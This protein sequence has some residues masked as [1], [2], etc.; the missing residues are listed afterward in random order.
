MKVS[1]IRTCFWQGV[2]I[3]PNVARADVDSSIKTD[4]TLEKVYNLYYFFHLYPNINNYNYEPL[5]IILHVYLWYQGV[6]YV[7]VLIHA[8]DKF[9][10]YD[11]YA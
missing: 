4:L 11:I 6:C 9:M 8:G 5:D 7:T 3:F 10:C 2:T 1:K